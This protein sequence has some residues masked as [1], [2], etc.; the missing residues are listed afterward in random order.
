VQR[1]RHHQALQAALQRVAAG[2]GQ[3]RS[4]QHRQQ[5]LPATGQRQLSAA[6]RCLAA[7]LPLGL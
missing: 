6:A 5:L 3:H 2:A 1:V 4:K 7:A